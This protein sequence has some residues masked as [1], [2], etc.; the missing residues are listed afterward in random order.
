MGW[1][2]TTWGVNPAAPQGSPS[3]RHRDMGDCPTPGLLESQHLLVGAVPMFGGW[4]WCDGTRCLSGDGGGGGNRKGIAPRCMRQRDEQ[5]GGGGA[6]ACSSHAAGRKWQRTRKGGS[7]CVV[8]VGAV[9]PNKAQGDDHGE[10]F[11]LG[12]YQPYTLPSEAHVV[13]HV[14]P[15][16]F[17]HRTVP[18]VHTSIAHAIG[19]QRQLSRTTGG[20]ACASGCAQ[21]PPSVNHTLGSLHLHP[22][23]PSPPHPVH[24]TAGGPQFAVDTHHS[25]PVTR[26]EG[27]K[28]GVGPG[29]APWLTPPV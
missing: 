24:S 6:R 13:G 15:L 3:R 9:F 16:P 28:G 11:H 27:A 12:A 26:V 21:R 18:L 17:H 1:P 7:V 14:S 4:G 10:T 23:H 22:S 5:K 20:P 19:H 8:G 29:P 2:A 25:T